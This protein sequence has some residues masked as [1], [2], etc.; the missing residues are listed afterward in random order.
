[1]PITEAR[2]VMEKPRVYD[3]VDVVV[4]RGTTVPSVRKALRR[5]LGR[6]IDIETPEGKSQQTQDQLQSLNVVL[7]FFA[8]MALFVG[9]FLI[10]NAFNMTVLQRLREIGMLRTLGA[11]GRMIARSV[12]REAL[13]LGMVGA[14]LGLALGVGLAKL[15]VILMRA[16]DFP[17]GNIVFSP[18]ALVA[19]LVVGLVTTVIGALYPARRAGRISPIQA[20]AGAGEG[21]K[22]PRPRRAVIGLVLVALGL[23]GVYVLASADTTPA[24]VAAAGIAGV[25]ALFLGIALASPFAIAPLVR[26]VS[27][28][29]RRLFPI[30]GRLAAD[31]ARANPGR[32]A[33]TTSGL[34]I[35]LALV[36]GFGSLGSSFL[37]S[38]SKEFDRSFARDLTVQPRGLTPGQGPQQTIASGLRQK[39]ERIPE[40][41]VVARERFFYTPRLP[42]PKKSDGLLLGFDPGDYE[43]VDSTKTKGVSRE[44]LFRRLRQ[45]WVSVGEGYANEAHLHP[46]DPI[47]LK[48]PSGQRKT[49]VAGIVRTVI[50]AGQTVGMSIPLLHKVYGVTS[51]T[52]YAITATSKSARPVLQ[53]KIERLV[54]RD[55]PNLVV[56]SNDELKS[57]IQTQLNQ[58]F[59]F[60]NAILAAAIIVSLFGIVNTLSMSVIERTREIG[61]LRALGS[62]RWQVRRTIADE[63]LVIALIGAL[64]GIVVGLGLGYVFVRGL[65][66]GIPGVSY[67]APITTI[68][69]V[70]VLGVI[71]GLL[72]S[73]LPARRAARLDVIGALSYE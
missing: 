48:G 60:F 36:V 52:E 15:L 65:A 37:H 16:L 19:A 43:K 26:A 27:L 5:R 20:V 47:T 10:F 64:L 34:M 73:I 18:S 44:L 46:G 28:P 40:A 45:G 33:A 8:G 70:A 72:A 58:Q 62:T 63:S 53:R 29:I 25:I 3:E 54:K 57:K 41:K 12:L 32:T 67:T 4:R 11:T 7:Y 9:G 31:S 66:A 71:L 24:P 14:A 23:A 39:I 22:P 55:Y 1:M 49:H 35:G 6:G 50:F 51:D 68:A 38:I 61:V 17:V 69:V 30:E 59:G 2:R 21:R 42:G 13:L 56:L